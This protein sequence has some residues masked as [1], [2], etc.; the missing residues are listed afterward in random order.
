MVMD[1]ETSLKNVW[2]H[3]TSMSEDTE[4]FSSDPVLVLNRHKN[5]RK[6]KPS[7]K[8]VIEQSETSIMNP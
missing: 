7:E 6:T 8:T 3:A 4:K 2:K 5:I 1:F